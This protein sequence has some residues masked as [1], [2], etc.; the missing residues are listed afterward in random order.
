MK[1]KQQTNV[2]AKDLEKKVQKKMGS[3][4]CG[5]SLCAN[6]KTPSI[7]KAI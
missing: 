1:N 5:S 6:N 3:E 2:S 4:F 7:N